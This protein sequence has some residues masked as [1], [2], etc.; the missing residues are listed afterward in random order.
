MSDCA[1]GA[2]FF[3]P[4]PPSN[5]KDVRISSKIGGGGLKIG[6]GVDD[7]ETYGVDVN[8]V[9]SAS[10]K[11]TKI[12]MATGTQYEATVY[13]GASWNTTY[14]RVKCGDGTWSNWLAVGK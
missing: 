5:R 13:H 1:A 8:G 2:K 11:S 7:V 9:Q 6:G 4:P 3:G 14:V 10:A 12:I